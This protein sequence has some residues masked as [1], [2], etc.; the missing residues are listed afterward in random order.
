MLLHANQPFGG[1]TARAGASGVCESIGCCG[2]ARPG[3]GRCCCCM[4]GAPLADALGTDCVRASRLAAAAA[5]AA[6]LAK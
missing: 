1:D 5:A 4:G 6:E 3:G 2:P